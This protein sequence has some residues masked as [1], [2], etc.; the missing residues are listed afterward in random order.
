MT[1]AW[2]LLG[3]TLGLATNKTLGAL[4]LAAHPSCRLYCVAQIPGLSWFVFGQKA[5]S[6]TCSVRVGLFANQPTDDVGALFSSDF[7]G[8]PLAVGDRAT[9]Q[10]SCGVGIHLLLWVL[11]AIP[12]SPRSVICYVG[13]GRLVVSQV[14]ELKKKQTKQ[15]ARKMCNK[16]SLLTNDQVGYCISMPAY[17]A[18]KAHQTHGGPRIRSRHASS[19][20]IDRPMSLYPGLQEQV[21]PL[22]TARRRS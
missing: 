16:R 19:Q 17:R 7:R 2:S 21:T 15:P 10:A 18:W 6:C 12:A 1:L 13:L 5:T 9:R 3:Q 14:Q 8:Y 20:C 22:V 4:L 11:F